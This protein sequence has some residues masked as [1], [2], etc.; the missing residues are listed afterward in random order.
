MRPGLCLVSQ[1]E[2]RR[3]IRLDGNRRGGKS[4]IGITGEDGGPLHHLWPQDTGKGIAVQP[5]KRNQLVGKT[6]VCMSCERPCMTGASKL[7]LD[8]PAV[9][10]LNRQPGRSLKRIRIPGR[11][12]NEG[13]T[14]IGDGFATFIQ[15]PVH[16]DRCPAETLDTAGDN[17]SCFPGGDGPRCHD[18]RIQTAAALPVEGQGAHRIG[19]PGSQRREPGRISTG[20]QRIAKNDFGDLSC[21]RTGILKHCLE[22]RNAEAG[23]IEPGQGPAARGHRRTPRRHDDDGPAHAPGSATAEH[24]FRDTALHWS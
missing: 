7:L 19:Q 24:R 23:E 8:D 10:L 13:R 9:A 20:T 16:A 22:D 5:G 21:G 2:H 17:D 6:P 18:H 14:I 11:I 1:N 15:W 4:M 12:G 3:G